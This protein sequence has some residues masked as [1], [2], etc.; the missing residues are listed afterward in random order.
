LPDTV[1]VTGATGFIGSSLCRAL[2]ARGFRVRAMHRATSSLKALEAL[3]VERVVGD[4][5]DP[6]SLPPAMDGVRWLF[7][8]AA[9]SAHWRQPRRVLASA[10]EG[11]RH[12]FRAA[13]EAGVRRAVLTSSLAALGVPAPGERLDERH[14]FNLPRRAFPYG[15]AK[16]Q[17]ERE[18]LGHAGEG[19][20]VVIVNPTVVLGAGDVHR[21]SGSLVIE[22]ARGLT[23][24]WVDGGT[25][26]VHIGDVVE[27]HL[28]ALERGR[29]G[30]RYILG[31]ENL[32][33]R[34]IFT[35]L[36][37]IVGRRPPWL[38]I[39]GWTIPPYAFLVDLLS[40]VAPLPVSGSLLRMSRHYLF[41]DTRKAQH[42]LGLTAPRPFRQAAQEA[43]DWYRREGVI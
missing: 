30:E 27:G 29:P 7:H 41:C 28:A 17:A 33:H 15:F 8:T 24:F 39:P 42:E 1:L 38:R 10:V 22:A 37:E 36:N 13:R 23:F 18:A 40:K 34:Q 9:Q 19:L 16:A 5:L 25:N 20:E 21:I 12:V 2:L 3:A 14:T 26:V 11:T 4:I 32:T 6:T 43:A 31:G 35:T